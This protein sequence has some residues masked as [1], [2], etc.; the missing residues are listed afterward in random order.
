M[1]KRKFDTLTPAVATRNDTA[2]RPKMP[3]VNRDH[4]ATA[5]LGGASLNRVATVLP[6]ATRNARPGGSP[7]AQHHNHTTQRSS[8]ARQKHCVC[9][10]S[11]SRLGD[12]FVSRRLSGPI[13]FLGAV[14]FLKPGLQGC[15]HYCPMTGRGM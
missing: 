3:V 5:F 8:V 10:R 2:P 1:L 7:I 9:R 15:R 13:H 4:K 11:V 12:H 6:S 14:I